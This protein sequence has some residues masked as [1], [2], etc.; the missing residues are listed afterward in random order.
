M[1]DRDRGRRPLPASGHP[2]PAARPGVGTPRRTAGVAA[3]LALWHSGHRIR[4]RNGSTKPDQPHVGMCTFATRGSQTPKRR[5]EPLPLTEVAWA[6]FC[7]GFFATPTLSNGQCDR[8]VARRLVEDKMGA[9]VGFETA[10]TD[11]MTAA[12]RSRCMS[13][14][15]GRDTKPE[16]ALRSALWRFGLRFLKKSRLPGR[17][18]VVFPR[19]HIAVFVDGCFWHRCPEHQTKPAANSEFWEEKLSGNVDRDRRTDAQ[20]KAEAWTVMRIWEHE[21]EEGAEAAARKV[22]EVV[23]ERRAT[24]R[25]GAGPHLTLDH[26]KRD[27]AAR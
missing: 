22:R 24:R 2:I 16:V 15:R 17:P 14:I 3:G 18:D 5:A 13:R 26:P 27:S 11:V 9:S 7:P 12:Q 6:R 25:A 20:L 19:E 23:L 4:L 21:V 1:S 8:S 10:M